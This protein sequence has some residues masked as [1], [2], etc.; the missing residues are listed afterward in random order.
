MSRGTKKVKSAGRFGARYGLRIRRRFTDVEV[1]QK[2][3]H[4]CPSCQMGRVKR[5]STGI[6]QCRKCEYKFAGGAYTPVA[7]SFTPPAAVE[8]ATEE[9][10]GPVEE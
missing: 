8:A 10:P 1:R 3:R 4:A 7:T 6:W 5:V 2:A 9:S